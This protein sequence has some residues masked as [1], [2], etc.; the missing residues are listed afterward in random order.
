MSA[1]VSTVKLHLNKR[2]DTFLTPLY[3]I[4]TVA[5]ISVLISLLFL[6]SGSV[7]ATADWIL[8]SRSNPGLAYGLAGFLVYFGVQAAATTFPFAL[9]LGATRRAFVTGTLL[10][11]ILVSAYVALTLAVL[12]MIEI[13]TDHWFAGFYVFDVFLLGAGNIG[14]LLPIAFLGTLTLLAIGGVFGASW[15]RLGARGPQFVGILLAIVIVVALIILL[16]SLGA[17]FA[18][19]QPWWLAVVAGV[20]II[21][22]SLA[23]WLF[24]RSAIVR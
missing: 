5:V 7:P 22:C 21:L 8:G 17:I 14:L 19:F 16:P 4:G 2:A 23:T 10:W 13:A 24:L 9:T 18:A 3:I 1:I 12:C 11:A 20:L 6:R 15:V